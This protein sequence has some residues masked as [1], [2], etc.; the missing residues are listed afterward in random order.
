MLGQL[1]AGAIARTNNGTLRARFRLYPIDCDVYGHMNN[2][3]YFRVAELARWRQTSQSGLLAVS[4]RERWM[5][6]IAEQSIKY[7]RSIQPFQQYYIRSVLTVESKWIFYDHYFESSDGDDAKLFAHI[8]MKAVVKRPDGKTVQPSEVED[9]C[10]GIRAWRLDH[11]AQQ[12]AEADRSLPPP[13][14]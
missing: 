14:K 12:H 1:V 3:N 5:F 8:R 6:L 2:A 10:P 11:S 4:L 13:A 7:I 9:K